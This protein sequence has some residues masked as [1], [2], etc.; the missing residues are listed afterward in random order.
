MY[1][2]FRKKPEEFTNDDFEKT[3]LLFNVWD[4]LANELLKKKILI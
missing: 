2:P 4:K 1:K 3:A